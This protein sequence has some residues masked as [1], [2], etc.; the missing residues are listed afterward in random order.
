MS[1]RAEIIAELREAFAGDLADAVRRIKFT[2]L[3][4]QAYDPET[5]TFEP[6]DEDDENPPEEVDGIFTG[7][8]QYEVFNSPAEPNDE[9]LLILQDDLTFRPPIGTLIES[10]RGKTRVVDVRSDPMDVTW[11]LRVR[12]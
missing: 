7:Q 4:A 6:V 11:E 3:I 2:K 12:F 8:W 5:S 9:T 10:S 1:E